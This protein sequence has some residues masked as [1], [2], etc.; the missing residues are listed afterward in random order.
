MLNPFKDRES[1][2]MQQTLWAIARSPLTYGGKAEDINTANEDEDINTANPRIAILTNPRVLAVSDTSSH[3]RQVRRSN[4]SAVWVAETATDGSL[5]VGLFSLTG[6]AAP[7]SA[8]QRDVFRAR[9]AG[10]RHFGQRHRPLE[11]RRAGRG[12]GKHHSSALS[13]LCPQPLEGAHRPVRRA[14]APQL[15]GRPRH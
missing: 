3:N 1:M 10:W 11:R 9:P 5:Y 8:R 6:P 4:S 14:A 13:V 15:V 2:L 7:V 12:P